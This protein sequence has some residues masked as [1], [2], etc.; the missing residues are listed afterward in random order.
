[1][2]SATV[3]ANSG[4]RADALATA[5]MVNGLD[6]SINYIHTHTNVEA[7]LIYSDESGGYKVWISENLKK[8]IKE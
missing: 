5:F 2:L 8:K 6:W 3:I 7:Y 1:L 4:A